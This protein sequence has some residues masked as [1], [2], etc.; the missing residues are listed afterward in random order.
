MNI[1]IVNDDNGVGSG[2]LANGFAT[3]K[4]DVALW[5]PGKM[6]VYQA[7]ARQKPDLFIGPTSSVT[8][9][10]LRNQGKCRLALWQDEVVL[11]TP[12]DGAFIFATDDNDKELPVIRW[13][14]LPMDGKSF[15]NDDLATDVVFLDGYRSGYDSFFMPLFENIEFVSRVYCDTPWPI[16][17]YA[18]SLTAQERTQA[19]ASSS[20]RAMTSDDARDVRA[21]YETIRVGSIPVV[22]GDENLLPYGGTPQSYLS[23][24]KSLVSDKDIHQDILDNLTDMFSQYTPVDTAQSLLKA[25]LT[26]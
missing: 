18:G 3:L 21:I 9:A 1:L 5:T 24:I 14:F 13:P 4:H 22:A 19:I 8:P 10:L 15:Y 26:C 11:E 12:P 6:P 2:A 23:M 25:M 17:Y 7:F 20:V 16:P